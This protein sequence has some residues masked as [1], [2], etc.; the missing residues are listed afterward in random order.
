MVA[1]K[2]LFNRLGSGNLW[3]EGGFPDLPSDL[4]A[5]YVANTTIRGLEQ[6]DVVLLIGTNPRVEAPVYN[7][8]LRKAFLDGT[9]V[10]LLGEAVDLTYPYEHLGSDA[11]ALAKLK[12]GG[13]F[14][15]ALKGAK[16]PVV[17]VGPG[18]LN[19][20]ARVF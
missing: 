7:A 12:Q 19:R 16:H 3:H 13:G 2:D 5:S 17:I 4:R 20:C 10:A 9:K 8:R 6:A 11:A 1:A 14:F 15:E 18:V